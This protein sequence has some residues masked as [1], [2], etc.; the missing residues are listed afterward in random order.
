MQQIILAAGKGTRLNARASN[1]CLVKVN[2]KCLID[3][4]LE[5]SKA[6]EAAEI[7]VVVGYNRSYIMEYIGSSYNGIPVRYVVQEPQFGIA[8]AIMKTADFIKDTFFM[9]LS[10]E[11]L[12]A[13]KISEQK[14]FFYC[15]N[16]DC[17]CGV[18]K[19]NISNIQKAYTVDLVDENVVVKIIEKPEIPYNDLKGTGY[20]MMKK[21]MLDCLPLLKQNK[22]R[23]EYE[24]GDW[25]N[26]S[27]AQ[28]CRCFAYKIG[29]M[30]FN[31]NEQLDLIRAEKCLKQQE[32]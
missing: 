10:D 20:C 25:I 9:C 14:D 13:P 15:S 24:M 8:H 5:F 18:V 7:I 30:N 12:I 23:N 17:V 16:A 29:F 27:I 2:G 28:N 32:V 31:I 4:N 3:Y 21:T 6:I 11:I 26:L 1:K 19:D 22:Q